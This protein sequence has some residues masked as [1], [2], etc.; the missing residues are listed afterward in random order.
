VTKYVEIAGW[1]KC[2]PEQVMTNFDLEQIVD[3]SDE[4]IRKGT[5]IS[6]RRIAGPG[7]TTATIATQAARQAMERAG[8]APE[9]LDLIIL[10]TASPDYPSFPATACLVQNALGAHNCA[11]FDLATACSGFIYGLVT[12][13]QFILTGTYRTVLVIGAETLSRYLD[14]TDRTTC[15]LFGDGAGAAVL[16]GTEREGGLMASVLGADGSGG[17]HLIIPGGGSRNPTTPETVQQRMH[18]LK[19]NGREVFKFAA[20][21]LPTVFHQTLQKAGIS[22]EDVDLLIPHQANSRIIDSARHNLK[23]ADEA[24]FM[25]VSRYGNTSAGSIPVALCEAIEEGRLKPGA[26]LSMVA[27]GAGLTWGSVLWRWQG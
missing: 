10:A 21:I 11:A 18:Y 9:E 8:V 1:G 17:E 16:R 2:L 15:V 23:L 7:E 13:S 4:W 12:G 5:G 20:R 27:F 19:M 25:N 3:T 24:I 14:W 22:P 6:E 26:I